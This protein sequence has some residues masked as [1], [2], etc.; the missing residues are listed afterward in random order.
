MIDFVSITESTYKD[1]PH[2]FEAG[3]PPIVE[4]IALAPPSTM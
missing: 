4:A 2:K 3:T 1:A